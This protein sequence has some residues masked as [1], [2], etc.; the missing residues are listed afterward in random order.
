MYGHAYT[1]QNAYGGHTYASGYNPWTG[2]SFATSQ[3]HNQ[4][5]SWGSTVVNN[6]NN[7]AEAQHYSNANGTTGSFQTSK[8]SAG[9]GVS[10]A[11]GNSGFVAKDANYN[12]V[13]AG[14]DGNVYKKDS[15]GNWSK[16]DNGSWTPVDPTT[17]ESEAKTNAQNKKS[18]NNAAGSSNSSLGSTASGSSA[19][20]NRPDSTAR[21]QRGSGSTTPTPNQPP[22]AGSSD[23]MGQLNND[24]GSRERGDQLENQNRNRGASSGA[25]SAR[26]SGGGTRRRP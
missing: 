7:W 12:N 21:D 15:S 18:G 3:G 14:A 17:A 26:G 23:T 11:N 13:Y 5:S 9:A 24:A 20:S 1:T 19:N 2:T 4:Y 6:G 10:G 8:G 25:G 16:Y 22:A